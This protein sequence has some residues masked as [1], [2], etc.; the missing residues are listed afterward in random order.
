MFFLSFF[1]LVFV[2]A[3][4]NLGKVSIKFKEKLH[5]YRYDVFIRFWI[6]TYLNFGVFAFANYE[7]VRNKK[8][9]L[10]GGTSY[11]VSRIFSIVYLV[12]FT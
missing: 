2:L 5:E 11:M 3:K 4:I 9:P 1:P 6:Q 12:I 10:I 8:D 7:S